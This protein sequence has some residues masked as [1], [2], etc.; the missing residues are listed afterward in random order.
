M[1]EPP[2]R[3]RE[4]RAAPQGNDRRFIGRTEYTPSGADVI[5]LVVTNDSGGACERTP[6]LAPYKQKSASERRELNAEIEPII[7]ELISKQSLKISIN[8]IHLRFL[9]GFGNDAPGERPI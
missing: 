6:G 7:L 9:Y 2:I 3:A 1:A 5:G 4:R 8:T